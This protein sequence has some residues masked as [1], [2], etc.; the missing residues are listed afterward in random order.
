MRWRLIFEEYSH[1]MIYIQGSKHIAAYALTKVDIVDTPN[2]I[3]HT[4]KSV[5]EY[6]GLEDEDI[7]YTLLIIKL[8]Y[9]MN[10]KTQN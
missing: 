5:N 10:R 1:E 3:K 6:Y 4:I 8:L 2:P 7:F 9:K